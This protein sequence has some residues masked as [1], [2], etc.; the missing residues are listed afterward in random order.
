[1][2]LAAAASSSLLIPSELIRLP[3]SARVASDLHDQRPAATFLAPMSPSSLPH[4]SSAV[5]DEQVGSTS[6]SA[7]APG[8]R[9]E[10]LHRFKLANCVHDCS[11]PARATPPCA[12]NRLSPKCR[13]RNSGH[14]GSAA[15]SRLHPSLPQGLPSLFPRRSSDVSAGNC[16]IA[17]AS[18]LEPSGLKPSPCNTRVCNCGHAGSA[19]ATGE[20]STPKSGFSCLLYTS[21]SPRDA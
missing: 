17:D 11:T 21:P 16:T 10:F 8:P 1:M 9:N 5:T 18:R 4:R 15:T 19:R 20:I 13:F 12:I 6:A 14:R 3:R 2:S 7:A